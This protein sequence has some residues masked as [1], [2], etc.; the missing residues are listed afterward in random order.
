MN[1]KTTE[2]MIMNDLDSHAFV[3]GQ[4]LITAKA[5]EVLHPQEALAS[6]YLHARG[7]TRV[8]TQTSASGKTIKIA[9]D[10][11][12][13]TTTLSLFGEIDIS[14]VGTLENW[15]CAYGCRTCG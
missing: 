8:S 6:L 1:E 2:R 4:T 13:G 12:K 5:R 11:G 14:E 7:T 15:V 10:A 3:L 9:T